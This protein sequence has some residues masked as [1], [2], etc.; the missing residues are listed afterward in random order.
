MLSVKLISTYKI[1]SKSEEAAY[2][3]CK[4][5]MYIITHASLIDNHHCIML[6]IHVLLDIIQISGSILLRT[7]Y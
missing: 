3:V 7:L 4:T 1:L 5:G 2:F 6:N